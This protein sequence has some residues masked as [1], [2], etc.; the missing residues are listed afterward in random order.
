[1]DSPVVDDLQVSI[2]KVEVISQ[3]T[4][5]KLRNR[6]AVGC[7]C[8]DLLLCD[9]RQNGVTRK[10]P[11]FPKARGLEKRSAGKRWV[12]SHRLPAL[13]SKEISSSYRETQE[14]QAKT[15]VET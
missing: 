1:V 15:S 3:R 8:S 6:G 4:S 10:T 9:K 14:L 12:K 2:S 13:A 5:L 7:F 11:S